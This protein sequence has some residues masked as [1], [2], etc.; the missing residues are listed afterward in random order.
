MVTE[1]KLQVPCNAD[2]RAVAPAGSFS[3][4][5]NISIC[6]EKWGG[7]QL[8]NY[9]FRQHNLRHVD[10]ISMHHYGRLDAHSLLGNK[11]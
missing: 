5:G 9:V 6:L 8:W 10:G 7:T 4:D 3:C 2:D 1:G 11:V